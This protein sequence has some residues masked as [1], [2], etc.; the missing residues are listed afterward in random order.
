MVCVRGGGSIAILVCWGS[1]QGTQTGP[2]IKNNNNN[3]QPCFS[4]VG[5]DAALIYFTFTGDYIS[6]RLCPKA[7]SKAYRARELLPTKISFV[8]INKL[9]QWSRNSA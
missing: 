5:F 4:P 8:L 2:V 6:G 7:E 1:G 3:S 9:F